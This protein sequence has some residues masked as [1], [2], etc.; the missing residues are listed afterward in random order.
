MDKTLR[1]WD[2]AWIDRVC[3]KLVRNFSRAE[4]K[5]YVGEIPY[6]KQCSGLPVPAD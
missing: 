6:V 5:Q 4:W 2:A 1:L 3:A